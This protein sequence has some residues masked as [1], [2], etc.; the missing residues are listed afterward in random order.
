M[1]CSLVFDLSCRRLERRVWPLKFVKEVRSR[2]EVNMSCASANQKCR[3]S[4]SHNGIC[5]RPQIVPPLDFKI[6]ALTFASDLAVRLQDAEITTITGYVTCS[7]RDISIKAN[8]S[9]TTVLRL[10]R[11]C[12]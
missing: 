3:G 8:S 10:Q 2:C 11:Q 9:L 7:E 12:R 4:S 5:L 6:D 1:L